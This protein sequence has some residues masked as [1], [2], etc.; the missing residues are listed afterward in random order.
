[1]KDKDALINWYKNNKNY[2]DHIINDLKKQTPEDVMHVYAYISKI[3]EL[4]YIVN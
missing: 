4:E 3:F 1:M 2:T